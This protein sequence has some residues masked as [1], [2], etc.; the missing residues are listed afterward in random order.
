MP[1]RAAELRQRAEAK[2]RSFLSKEHRCL[3]PGEDGGHI[4]PDKASG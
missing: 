2:R 1:S 4:A 3:Q